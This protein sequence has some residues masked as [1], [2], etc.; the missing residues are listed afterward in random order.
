MSRALHMQS[1]YNDQN[2][3]RFIRIFSL[4]MKQQP[5]KITMKQMFTFNYGLFKSVIM[6]KK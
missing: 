4:H 1:N 5:I 2:Y 3:Q 6:M